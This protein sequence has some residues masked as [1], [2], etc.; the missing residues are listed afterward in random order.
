[1]A[2]PAPDD[3]PDEGSPDLSSFL[4]PLDKRIERVVALG[5]QLEARPHQPLRRRAPTPHWSPLVT[6]A[7]WVVGVVLL[8]IVLVLFLALLA[9]LAALIYLALLFELLLVAPPVVL[10]HVLLR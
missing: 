3:E 2:V 5:A 8:A 10:V 4:P 6:V 7:G 9:C 1:M